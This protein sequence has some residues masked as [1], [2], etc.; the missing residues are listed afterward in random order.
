MPDKKKESSFIGP[1][2]KVLLK[3]NEQNKETWEMNQINKILNSID[4]TDLSNITN[5]II[6]LLNKADFIEWDLITT[7]ILNKFSMYWYLPQE[8]IRDIPSDNITKFMEDFIWDFLYWLRTDWLNYFSNK[9]KWV[10]SLTNSIWQLKGLDFD[11]KVNILKWLKAYSKIS[12]CAFAK[13]SNKQVLAIFK[14]K[15]FVADKNMQISDKNYKNDIASHLIRLAL[16]HLG[17]ER[18]NTT[19]FAI[20]W[21]FEILSK[22]QD[23]NLRWDTRNLLVTLKWMNQIDRLEYIHEN[24]V[25]KWY[26]IKK[27]E[28]CGYKTNEAPIPDPNNDYFKNFALKYIQKYLS[29]LS[30]HQKKDIT[31]HRVWAYQDSETVNTW[32][33]SYV[34]IENL[35]IIL[36]TRDHKAVI[37]WIKDFIKNDT[38]PLWDEKIRKNILHCFAMGSLFPD[39][40]YQINIKK[41]GDQDWYLISQFLIALKNHKAWWVF[42]F[43]NDEHFYKYRDY[44]KAYELLDSLGSQEEQWI[45][46]WIKEFIK[47]WML[48]LNDPSEWVIIKDQIVAMFRKKGFEAWFSIESLEKTG[49]NY[50]KYL[51]WI[52]LDFITNWWNVDA[53]VE[54]MHKWDIIYMKIVDAYE[55]LEIENGKLIDEKS[56]GNDPIWYY[57]ANQTNMWIND[58]IKICDVFED[59]QFTRELIVKRLEQCGYTSDPKS[60]DSEFN[61]T[62]KENDKIMMAEFLQWFLNWQQTYSNQKWGEEIHV[63]REIIQYLI[64][65]INKFD[66]DDINEVIDWI[67][68]LKSDEINFNNSPLIIRSCEYPAFKQMIIDKFTKGWFKVNFEIE[69]NEIDPDIYARYVIWKFLGFPQKDELPNDW[70]KTMETE[71]NILNDLKK[72][73]VTIKE[74]DTLDFTNQKNVAKW[75]ISFLKLDKIERLL[76]NTSLR[77]HI[78]TRLTENSFQPLDENCQF[79]GDNAESYVNFAI[80]KFVHSIN[81][82]T[83]TDPDKSY[84]SLDLYR[85]I[86]FW[87]TALERKN[88]ISKSLN[89]FKTWDNQSLIELF[90]ILKDSRD[91]FKIDPQCAKD[92]YDKLVNLWFDKSNTTVNYNWDRPEDILNWIRDSFL[93]ILDDKK[94]WHSMIGS[95]DSLEHWIRLDIIKLQKQLQEEIDYEEKKIETR[96]FFAKE[97]KLLQKDDPIRINIF[98][99]RINQNWKHIQSDKQ[100]KE[101][102]LNKFKSMWYNS[103]KYDWSSFKDL[104]HDNMVKLLI[105][106]IMDSIESWDKSSFE[107]IY[108]RYIYRTIRPD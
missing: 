32:I 92:V 107:S 89:S 25:L 49:N 60:I 2:L 105:E 94:E 102:I 26:F 17:S 42:E 67:N 5:W 62:K 34:L 13:I 35:P 64:P 90:Y 97:I 46:W 30:S 39:P 18:W 82:N 59:N 31:G 103:K 106:S 4:F 51:I 99:L 52:F 73:D 78:F 29:V 50:S 101:I 44:K 6:E 20:A 87:L 69:D 43:D 21:S 10:N 1:I 98:I 75:I 86:L 56:V 57:R 70:I 16:S 15:G 74:F 77:T 104:D 48:L 76:K 47:K 93:F 7:L 71:I 36:L 8:W 100:T 95:F 9:Y 38:T 33:N 84:F 3:Q 45:T 61:W 19:T 72:A 40:N 65:I 68:R 27:F 83:E 81:N 28:S 37:S 96:N 88:M 58:F 85:K 24:N 55:Q 53:I 80:W 79:E 12:N 54:K 108:D 41:S 22:F 11:N 14:E 23:L 66:F 63:Q 91:L